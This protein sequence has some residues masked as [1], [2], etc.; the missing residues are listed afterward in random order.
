RLVFLQLDGSQHTL[1]AAGSA[2]FSGERQ[3]GTVTSVAQH[4]EMGPVA[5]AVIKRSVDAQ[6]VLTVDDAGEKYAAAQ[7]VIVAPDAGQVVGRRSGF[8]RAPR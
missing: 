6:A 1:P 4:Y 3:V 8:L 2:V 5:L 7:E